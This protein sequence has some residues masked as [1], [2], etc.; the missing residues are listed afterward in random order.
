MGRN[1]NGNDVRKF[2]FRETD[3]HIIK[4]KGISREKISSRSGS[5]SF[6]TL[7]HAYLELLNENLM[8]FGFLWDICKQWKIRLRFV[9]KSDLYYCSIS[10]D[11]LADS[12]VCT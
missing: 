3:F 4:R 5:V 12:Y 10:Y 2:G 7:Y 6:S 1:N 11:S 9:S 8:T